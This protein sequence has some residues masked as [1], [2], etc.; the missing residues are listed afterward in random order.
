MKNKKPIW[1]CYPRN[2]W[3]KAVV[4]TCRLKFYMY[5]HVYLHLLHVGHNRKMVNFLASEFQ[6]I[7]P[8]ILLNEWNLIHP[9]RLL[10]YTRASTCITYNNNNNKDL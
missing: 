7:E 9:P 5:V 1:R 8:A 6:R 10:L 3:G 2:V 4:I